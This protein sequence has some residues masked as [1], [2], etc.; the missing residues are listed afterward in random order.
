MEHKKLKLSVLLFGLGLTIQAQQA[1]TAA[2]GDAS[3]SGGSV[4][5]S[6]G[7]VAYITVTGPTGSV[8]QGVEQPFEIF[9]LSTNEV[10]ATDISI[11]VFPNPTS[12]NLILQVGDFSTNKLSYQLLDIRG[13]LLNNDII[14]AN[15][16]QLSLANLPQA[17]YF[18]NITRQNKK[19]KAFKILKN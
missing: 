4:A 10:A 16:T 6:V 15:Q 9:V 8:V 14:T 3:G 11:S 17:A 1:P 12:D 2:G 19:V 5:Y 7:Q 18:V 13:R